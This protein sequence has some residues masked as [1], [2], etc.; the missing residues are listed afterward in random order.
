MHDDDG[1]G[2][3]VGL[4]D[5]DSD[6]S[7]GRSESSSSLDSNSW[8]PVGRKMIATK[9]ARKIIN[10]ILT[11]FYFL[12]QLIAADAC[13]RRRRSV[14]NDADAQ[15]DVDMS[16]GATGD[17]RQLLQAWL[18]PRKKDQLEETT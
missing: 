13:R 18:A 1:G 15:N 14:V 7:G 5:G 16:N 8:P 4:S 17:D 11:N 9:V 12:L 2:G 10:F 6:I 3:G